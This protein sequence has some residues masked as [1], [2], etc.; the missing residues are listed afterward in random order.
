VNPHFYRLRKE[1]ARE[2]QVP[3]S[4]TEIC[5]GDL[6]RLALRINNSNRIRV[7]THST[8]LFTSRS[9]R[10]ASI[11]DQITEFA[12]DNMSVRVGAEIY[13]AGY[14]GTLTWVVG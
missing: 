1:T 10:G 13:E 7:V 11:L 3:R 6:L 9:I 14:L 12:V 5:G 8:S 4:A 2:D